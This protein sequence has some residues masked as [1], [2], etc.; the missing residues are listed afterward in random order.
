ML[1]FSHICILVFLIVLSLVSIPLPTFCCKTF[2]KYVSYQYVQFMST[3][4]F[5][6]FADINTKSCICCRFAFLLTGSVCFYIFPFVMHL[7]PSG[8]DISM[9]KCDSSLLC[10]SVARVCLFFTIYQLYL[11]GQGVNKFRLQLFSCLFIP[12]S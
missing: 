10:F 3:N 11:Q 8:N 7:L 4:N 1:D 2:T 12:S 6:I 9:N 5:V